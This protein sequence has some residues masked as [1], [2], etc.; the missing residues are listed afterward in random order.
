MKKLSVFLAL[1]GLAVTGLGQAPVALVNGEPITQEE[2]ES[3]TRLN[4]ILF[5]LYFQYPRFA[6]S[7][8]GTPEGKAFLTRYQRDVLEELILRKIQVQEARAR[9]LSADP[10]RVEELVNQTLEYIKR[11]YDLTEEELVAELAQEGL[12]LEAFKARLRPQ[13]EEQA[14]L[15]ALK[16]AVTA[17]VTVS[18]EEIAAYYQANLGQ[19]LDAKGQPLPLAEVRPK[20]AAFLAGQRQEAL[21]QEWL[22]RAR[23]T[24]NV[25][26]NL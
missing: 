8:L 20:I 2:L 12:T 4:Q 25:Q 24:A 10:A 22:K 3:A 5:Q 1:V 14:L 23:E 21:W 26:I 13:A 17:A 6:Q 19:F 7:L 18:E 9:K 11:Y 16:Q 15:E